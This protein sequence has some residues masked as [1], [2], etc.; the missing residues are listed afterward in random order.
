MVFPLLVLLLFL[1]SFVNFCLTILSIAWLFY[2]YL[3]KH[4][5]FI[6]AK[7]SPKSLRLLLVVISKAGNQ[8]KNACKGVE[9]S[10]STEGCVGQLNLSGGLFSFQCYSSGKLLAVHQTVFLLPSNRV[11]SRKWLSS[12]SLQ[13]AAACDWFLTTANEL[14]CCGSLQDEVFKKGSG[15]FLAL[16]LTGC[17]WLVVRQGWQGP[18]TE[19]NQS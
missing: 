12:P 19:G 15:P 10:C 14:W 1:Y 13:L 5:L 7:L 2:R 18:V 6:V 17:S 4:S 8:Q 9:L 16:L 11:A 3:R